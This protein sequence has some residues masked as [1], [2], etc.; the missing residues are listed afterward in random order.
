MQIIVN[1]QPT[2]ITE[3]ATVRQ[4]IERFALKGPVAVELNRSI[5]RK[6]DHENTHLHAG[7]VVEIVTA[8]GGG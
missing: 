8:V 5:C 3:P 2:E 7:D 6:A 1:G 4:L